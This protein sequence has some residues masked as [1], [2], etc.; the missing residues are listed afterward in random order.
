MVDI[1]LILTLAQLKKIIRSKQSSTRDGQG[2][3]CNTN[4]YA[5]NAKRIYKTP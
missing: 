4:E 1:L 2:P 3:I 5:D